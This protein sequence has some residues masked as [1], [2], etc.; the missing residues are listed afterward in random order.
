MNYTI[1][2]CLISH[3]YCFVGMDFVRNMATCRTC[4]AKAVNIVRVLA[5]SSVESARAKATF[6]QT[7][8]LAGS[9]PK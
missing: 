4:S 1:A 5:S 6:R 7:L 3:N 9:S 2:N 8:N